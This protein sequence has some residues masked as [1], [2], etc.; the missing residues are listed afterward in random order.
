MFWYLWL[1]SQLLEI[2]IN[3]LMSIY[4]NNTHEPMREKHCYGVHHNKI[5]AETNS[6]AFHYSARSFNFVNFL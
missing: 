4:Y 1:D 3:L 6:K 5:F 2:K